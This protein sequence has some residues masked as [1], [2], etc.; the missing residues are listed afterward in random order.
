MAGRIEAY[1]HSDTMTQNKGACIVEVNCQTDFA[2]RTPEFIEFS[3]LVARLAYGYGAQ[4]WSEL[5]SLHP[6]IAEKKTAVEESLGEKVHFRRMD[7]MDLTSEAWLEAERNG[8][9]GGSKRTVVRDENGK[10]IGA[11]G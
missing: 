11:Q 5:V 3:K 6:E 4:D 8:W 9:K 2:A 1:V 7:K 10:I